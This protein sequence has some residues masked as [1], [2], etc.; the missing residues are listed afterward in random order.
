MI[1]SRL[2][3][4][5]R[6]RKYFRRLSKKNGYYFLNMI[7][8]STA[9]KVIKMTHKGY[10]ADGIQEYS[11]IPEGFEKYAAWLILVIEQVKGFL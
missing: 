6:K 3:L 10:K 5:K 11:E 4:L 1:C 9:A 2:L 7:L 8:I